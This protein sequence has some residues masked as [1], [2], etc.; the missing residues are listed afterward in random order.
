MKI[1]II[2]LTIL[3]VIL[4]VLLGGIAAD[5]IVKSKCLTLK[6]QSQ[7]FPQFY[8]TETQHEMCADIGITIN[9]PVKQ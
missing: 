6:Q 2:A 9:A 1:N 8:L 7:K 4:F 3:A 5:K